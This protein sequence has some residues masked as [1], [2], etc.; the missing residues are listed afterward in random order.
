MVRCISKCGDWAWL[1]QVLGLQG[2]RGEGAGRRICWICQAGFN[3][4]L[5]C[6]DFSTGAPW[7]RSLVSMADF[8]A[9]CALEKTYT[10]TIWH[11]PGFHLSCVRLDWMHLADLGILQAAL[12]N[13]FS[14][15]WAGLGGGIRARPAVACA[16]LL[17]LLKVAAQDLGT[18]VP[19]ADLTLGMF[20]GV[21][22][23][24][25]KMKLKAA[26]GRYM[27]PIVHRLLQVL[28]ETD[29]EH[30]RLR[31]QCI[32]ALDAAYAKLAHW[33]GDSASAFE[34][35]SLARRHLLKY[36]ELQRLVDS[37]LRWAFL[38]K[39]HLWLH[40]CEQ[41]SCNPRLEWNYGD[42]DEIGQA[43]AFAR[44]SHAASFETAFI[45]RGRI[46]FEWGDSTSM[47]K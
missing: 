36:G 33:Q 24:R 8:W 29:S 20:H 31:L 30:A 35:G 11:I 18:R 27:L 25:P 21:A 40:L 4:T 34:L 6:H 9:S 41:C 5:H 44:G 19:V 39:H 2:W 32:A 43:A 46:C 13:V 14:E 42:E 3:D 23:K 22:K 47:N 10:S 7:R 45:E 28:W 12:G 1:K 26:E 15:L 16:K 38:P 17:N 37:G